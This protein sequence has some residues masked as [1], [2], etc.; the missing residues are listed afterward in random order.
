M[1]RNMNSIVLTHVWHVM[2]DWRP[3]RPTELGGSVQAARSA[4]PPVSWG[5]Q[6]ASEAREDELCGIVACTQQL[7]DDGTGIIAQDYS[8][9]K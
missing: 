5:G 2:I 4:K 3:H 6:S 9:F 8:Q 7:T 1:Q